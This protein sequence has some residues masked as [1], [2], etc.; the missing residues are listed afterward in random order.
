MQSLEMFLDAEAGIGRIVPLLNG[1]FRYEP[2][3]SSGRAPAGEPF[4]SVA[5]VKASL[6]AE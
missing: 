1:T 3:S 6:E 4:A 2:K 5:L